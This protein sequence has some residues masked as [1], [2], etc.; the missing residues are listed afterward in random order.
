MRETSAKEGGR[1]VITFVSKQ[2]LTGANNGSS[3]YLLALAQSLSQAGFELHLLQ[4]SPTIAGRSPFLKI[5]HEMNVFARH[6]IRGG[7]RLGARVWFI[8]AKVLAQAVFGTLAAFGRK[9]GFKGEMWRDRPAPYA[10]STPWLDADLTFLLRTMAPESKAVVAD[11]MFCHPAFECA[12]EQAKTAIVMH[13]LFHART[14][15]GKD[16]VAQVSAADEIATL[17][18]AQTVFAI[19]PDE[20]AF[21]KREVPST[22]AVLAPMPA[23]PVASAQPGRSD[24]LLMVGS[25]TAPNIEGLRDFLKNAWPTIHAALPNAVLEV[26]GTMDRAFVGETWPN[27]RFLGMVDK[28]DTLYAQA[29]LV[30]S[31]L[32]F[33]S[34]LKIKLIEGMANGKAMV[35]T[36]VTLQG[37]EEICRPGVALA[38]TGRDT[39]DH[40]VRLLSDDTERAALAQQALEIARKHFAAQTV[41][42]ELRRWAD[43]ILE[44]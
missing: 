44:S 12:P 40:V 19:Q 2:R 7:R 32:T 15:D 22:K 37:V 16:S 27:V 11:Y 29:G 35:V 5:G 42:R 4:P 21:L 23:E 20:A 24:Q 28:L 39:A 14:G 26:A 1:P 6:E 9:L 8:N 34:G 38:D 17:G 30:V 43:G 13:D 25:N 33:G 18:K 10:V 3:T 36:S 41:H 31:P